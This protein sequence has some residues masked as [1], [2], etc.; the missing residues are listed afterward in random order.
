MDLN[1]GGTNMPVSALNMFDTLAILALVPIF[2]GYVYPFFKKR[3]MPL[4]MLGKICESQSNSV[5]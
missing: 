3:Q 1:V 5:K 4:T 2:D